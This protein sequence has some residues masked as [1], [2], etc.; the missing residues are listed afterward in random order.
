MINPFLIRLYIQTK[1]NLRDLQQ[2]PP[3]TK[4][5][6][7]Y[8]TPIITLVV[9]ARS[10]HNWRRDQYL[11]YKANLEA[12]QLLES[13]GEKV[14]EREWLGYEESGGSERATM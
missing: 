12:V 6:I 9:L 11:V 3:S 8:T 13:T 10:F 2:K 7:L 1:A 4:T 5:L 14:L